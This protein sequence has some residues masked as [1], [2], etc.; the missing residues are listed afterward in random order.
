MKL[1]Q[2][3]ICYGMGLELLKDILIENPA[4]V[5]YSELKSN[6]HSIYIYE[7][8]EDIVGMFSK[9]QMKSERKE[10]D[11][12]SS[13]FIVI[14]NPDLVVSSFALADRHIH[15]TDDPARP[16]VDIRFN[17]VSTVV[18]INVNMC[19]SLTSVR[20]VG[21]L[22]HIELLKDTPLS[23]DPIFMLALDRLNDP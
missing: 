23:L 22:N 15:Q 5:Q 19:L 3:Y 20:G 8:M 12:D 4:I 2:S 17:F 14:E 9:W 11:N 16:A 1:L 7:I 18:G 21:L 10:S 13:K 6:P